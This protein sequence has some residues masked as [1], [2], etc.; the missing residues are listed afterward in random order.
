MRKEDAGMKVSQLMERLN[1]NSKQVEEKNEEIKRLRDQLREVRERKADIDIEAIQLK[2]ADTSDS[3]L[4]K[5]ELQMYELQRLTELEEGNR[6]SADKRQRLERKIEQLEEKKRSL[7]L[8]SVRFSER[9]KRLESYR[10][11]D[12]EKFQAD[13]VEEL[14]TK[15]NELNADMS[16][17]PSPSP[18]AEAYQR[19]S[20]KSRGRTKVQRRASLERVLA[21]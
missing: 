12:R 15:K 13:K 17:S 10:Q 21:E 1:E 7:K 11:H 3:Q 14:I 16:I 5:L 18:R 20:C 6:S 19:Q 2:V 8:E 4:E 9:I